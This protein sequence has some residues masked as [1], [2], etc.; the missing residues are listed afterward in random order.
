MELGTKTW[1]FTAR[2]VGAQVGN[3]ELSIDRRGMLRLGCAI[4][5]ALG[6]A[7]AFARTA[8]PDPSAGFVHVDVG[9]VHH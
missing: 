9:P 3:R 1:K 8:A 2:I 5:A 4:F 7:P 6:G